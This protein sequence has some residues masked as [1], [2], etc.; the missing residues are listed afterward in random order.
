MRGLD[1]GYARGPF[2]EIAPH[3]AAV[4]HN[5]RAGG[6][7]RARMRAAAR[8]ACNVA[9]RLYCA[10]ELIVRGRSRGFLPRN[11]ARPSEFGRDGADGP[12]KKFAN[13]RRESRRGRALDVA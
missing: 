7:S 6:G 3:L 9:G 5:G 13:E 10:A 2:A 8:A 4:H 12:P 1:S 11:E